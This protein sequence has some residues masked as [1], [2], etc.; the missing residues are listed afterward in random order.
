M[1]ERKPEGHEAGDL[2]NATVET[3]T[4]YCA[5]VKLDEFYYRGLLYV[6]EK[7][8]VISAPKCSVEVAAENS[9]QAECVLQK[10]SQ[11]VVTAVSKEGGKGSFRREK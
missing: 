6:S 2:V 10:A 8:Y 4:D 9:K 7:L 1:A 11:N 5:Y 3:V